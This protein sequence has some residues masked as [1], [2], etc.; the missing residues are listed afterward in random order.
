M[1]K[2]EYQYVRKTFT[3][4]GKRYVVYGKTEEEAI[5]KKIELKRKLEDG[6]VAETK[7]A[8]VDQWF[9]RWKEL[10]KAEQ[11]ITAKSLRMYDEKYQNYIQPVV[12]H[13][14]MSAVTEMQLQ[15]VMN[16]TADK[17]RST[18]LKVRMVI[19]QMFRRAYRARMIPFDP[20]EDLQIPRTA[21]ENA[22]RSL[23]DDERR[24]FLAC[25]P[26]IPCAEILLAMYYTGMRPGELMAL[27]WGD[28]DFDNNEI[29]VTKTVESGSSGKIKAPKTSAGIRMIPLR[30]P[31]RELL[32][33]KQGEPGDYVFRNQA[34]NQQNTASFDRVWQST[35]RAMDIA[36]GAMVYRNKII[37]ST[38]AGDLVPYCL[39]HTFCTDL[40]AAGV[41][42]NV[43]KMLMGHSDISVTANI[44]THS[45][46]DTL[47]KNMEKVDAEKDG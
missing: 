39:R 10:Y 12:G 45:D 26:K 3:F 16:T 40:Q 37:E 38:L 29:S 31:L 20:S 30:K 7:D 36:N 18:A 46:R 11:G 25:A 41:P 4:G 14:K 35:L 47:H 24:L 19:Q 21:T 34:G 9:A 13:K 1:Q 5:E 28:I 6:A 22:R 2:K 17:S 15:A 23:T 27:T 32:E 44:Y 8:T 42:I 43:A 33:P